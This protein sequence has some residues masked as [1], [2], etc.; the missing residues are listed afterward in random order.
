MLN[1]SNLFMSII[2]PELAAAAACPGLRDAIVMAV[3]ANTATLRRV[4]SEGTDGLIEMAK[5][6][7]CSNSILVQRGT[8]Y[9]EFKFVEEDGISNMK[10]LTSL[11]SE[12]KD[13]SVQD[14]NGITYENK[15]YYGFCWREKTAGGKELFCG[16]YHLAEVT[17]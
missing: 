10:T 7:S 16:C 14:A 2:D 13:A 1:N 12:L 6:F 17:E 8:N 9:K 11:L 5:E 15:G 4:P 3:I